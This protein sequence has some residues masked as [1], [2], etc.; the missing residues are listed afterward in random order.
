MLNIFKQ[1]I[2]ANNL[3][4]NT[5]RLLIAV[6]GGIDS[7]VLLDLIVKAGFKTGIAH[8]NFKIR[9]KESDHDEKFVRNLAK[10]YGLPVYINHFNTKK[11]AKEKGISVQMAA[12]ELRYEWFEQIR[13]E[14]NFDYIVIAHNR[15]DVA[16]TFLLNLAR[17][18]GI[19]GLTGI[20]NKS[21]KIVRPLLFS[22]RKE[23]EKYCRFN[24]LSYREDSSNKSEKY[25]RNLVRHKII[26]LF[27]KLNPDFSNTII[28]NSEH[29]SEIQQIFNNTITEKLHKTFITNDNNIFEIN[30]PKIRALQPLQTYL[31]EFLRLYNFT[32]SVT[33]KII[34]SLD[35]QAGKL[36]YSPTH[37]LIK[38]RKNL[39]IHP[40][41]Q[42]NNIRFF[43]EKDTAN[44]EFPL[45]LS[46]KRVSFRQNFSI[47]P[48]PA[49]A[50]LDED[51][52]IYPLILRHWRS[53]DYFLPFGIKGKK[54]LSD[55]FTDLKLSV[56]EKENIWI[57]ETGDKIVWIVGHRIDNR[58]R[59][60]SGTKNILKITNIK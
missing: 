32:S 36:F 41:V 12:R 23:I 8:C 27:N 28:K 39:I 29:L 35:S 56:F 6:S 40:I 42:N 49:I 47:P 33:E 55:F 54:K 24:N 38:D 15:D 26:P 14:K 25:S 57:L 4:N 31:F 16:E 21:G 5:N 7:V 13:Q 1:Y 11:Y 18:T 46:I 19:R 58:F 43:I 3:F 53:G 9:S 59:I 51:K 34:K 2:K 20:K 48:E 45:H 60:S 52:I 17:G 50:C 44:I 30:I 37:R 10:K 22:T